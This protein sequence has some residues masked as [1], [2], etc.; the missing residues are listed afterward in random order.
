MMSIFSIF[1]SCAVL[2]GTTASTGGTIVAHEATVSCQ[3]LLLYFPFPAAADLPLKYED[4]DTGVDGVTFVQPPSPYLDL[5]YSAFDVYGSLLPGT[6]PL[7][8]VETHSIPQGILT[9]AVEQ[10]TS[11]TP[12]IKIAPPYKSVTFESFYFGCSLNVPEGE[13]DE[14]TECTVTVKGF[15]QANEQV[16]I[17]QFTFDSPL[18]SIAKVPQVLVKFD[19]TFADIYRITLV[20]D[21]PVTQNLLIDNLKYTVKK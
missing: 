21:D 12:T 11:G 6:L 5:T 9:S 1:T 15:N 2:I 17:K 3:P 10:A 14:A 7:T 18:I 4:I 8:G 16:A 13:A 19:R 20:Q